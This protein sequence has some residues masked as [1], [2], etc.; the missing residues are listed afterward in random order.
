[1]LVDAHVVAAAA[2]LI[3]VD[4][5]DGCL[6]YD[7]EAR[8]L[9]LVDLDLYA[10]PYVLEVDRQFG[11]DRLMPPEEYVRGAS[12][13]EPATVYTLARLAWHLGCVR[14]PAQLDVVL[15]AT[16]AD[17]ARRYPTVAV[18]AAAWRD[19]TGTGYGAPLVR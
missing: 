3:A 13:G 11:S 12:V 14:L 8:E 5:Y 15:N 1:M 4:L 17:P 2:G 16:R 7:F 6:V 9:H 10:A 18:Y 19:A